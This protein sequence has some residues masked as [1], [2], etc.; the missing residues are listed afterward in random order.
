MYS[1]GASFMQL[2]NM[3]QDRAACFQFLQQRSILHNPRLCA[4]CNA[5]MKENLWK[6]YRWR[7][8]ARG[9]RTEVGVRVGTWLE[10]ANLPYGKIIMFLYAWSREEASIDFCK[11]ELDIG[12]NSV[13][14]WSNF[15]RKVC[16]ADLLANP[17]VIGGPGT[18]VEVDES[19]FSRRKNH[20]GRVLPQQWVFGGI[21]RETRESFMYTVPDRSEATL[22]SIIQQSVLPGAT[23]MSDM[24]AAYG[25]IAAMGLTHLQVNHTY[26]FVDPVTGAHTQNIENSW[27][28]AKSRNKRQHGTHRAMVDSYLCEW[29]WRQRN[30]NVNLFDKIFQDIA[31]HFPPA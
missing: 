4:N 12:H 24:W 31:I 21:C 17:L 9:C 11:H 5:P 26:N 7:C 20:Q 10:K 14:E 27:K 25:S 19:L 28:N 15:A 23:I 3:V 1:N 29:M 13:V 16:A 22:L 8:S 6:G 18:V 30:R 2:A